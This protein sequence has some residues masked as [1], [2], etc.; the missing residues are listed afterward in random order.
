[1]ISFTISCFTSPSLS[2]YTINTY[3]SQHD[4][5]MSQKKQERSKQPIHLEY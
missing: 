2:K 5:N 4:V 1:M 3:L